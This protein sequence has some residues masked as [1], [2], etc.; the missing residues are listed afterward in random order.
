MV[1]ENK[2]RVT[3]ALTVPNCP[4]AN[5]IK[6]DIKKALESIKGVKA[7]DIEL[8]SMTKEE[9]DAFSKSIQQ[10]RRATSTIEKLEKTHKEF[11]CNSIWERRCG[12]ILCN[13]NAGCRTKEARPRGWYI[14]C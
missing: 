11:N 1:N 7:V 13:W 12:K 8:T 5:T 4:L 6:S 9:L 14:G 3:V 2:V 10:K